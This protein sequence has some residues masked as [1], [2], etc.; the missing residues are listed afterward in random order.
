M[1]FVILI[2]LLSGCSFRTGQLAAG[3]EKVSQTETAITEQSRAMTTGALDALGF[4]P[5]NAPTEVARTLL[6]RDQQIEG[7]PLDRI[8]V[9]PLIAQNSEAWNRLQV[10]FD[11]Q[12]DLLAERFALTAQNR[13]LETDLIEM[14]TKYEAE[15]NKSIVRRIWAWSLGT[16]GIGGLIALGLLCPFLIPIAGSFVGWIVGM[17]PKLAGW[18]GVVGRKAFDQIVSGVEQVRHE[19]K[20]DPARTFTGKE[21]LGLMKT[22]LQSATDEAPRKLVAARKESLRI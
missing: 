8:D 18:V 9:R 10:R 16:L 7:L 13:K 2:M 14:G 22:E 12:S 17:V 3:R 11:F 21:V 6:E 20:R 4:A 1:R 5:T 15:R 19:L